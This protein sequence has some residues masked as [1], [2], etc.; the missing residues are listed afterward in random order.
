MKSG[1]RA[2]AEQAWTGK[3]AYRAQAAPM[4]SL[5]AIL[6]PGGGSAAAPF[7]G[8]C[9]DECK[10][11]IKP[12]VHGMTKAL[13]AEWVVGQLGRAIG[14]PVCEVE[15]VEIPS[16]LLPCEFAPGRPLVAGIGC[17]SRDLAGTPQE[18]RMLAHREVI[19]WAIGLYARYRTRIARGDFAVS[20]P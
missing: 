2:I 19:S 20:M 7:L 4:L 16:A 3:S 15:L 5:R 6:Q 8:K 14:A 17:A 12:P 9:S 11:W 1:V 10:W 18:L 13:V